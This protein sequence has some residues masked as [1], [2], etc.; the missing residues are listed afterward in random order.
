MRHAKPKLALVLAVAVTFL[1]PLRTLRAQNAPPAPS[2]AYAQAEAL[3]RAG[4]MDEGIAAAK[5]VLE[6]EPRNL[7][8]LNLLGIA[9][10]SKGDLD[11]ANREYRKAL[12]ID[13]AFYHALKN[14][15]INEL[16]QKNVAGAKRDLTAALKFA[17]NDPAIHASLGKIAYAERDYSTAVA[18]LSKIDVSKDAELATE[19]VESDLQA[20]QKTS[21]EAV[22]KQF[23]PADFSDRQQFR[24][25]LAL[26][27]R[28]L[29]QD[30]VPYFQAVSTK[31]PESYDAAF[32]LA[33]CLIETKQFPQAIEVLRSSA[34]QSHKT[35]E[36]D[37]LLAEAYEGNTQ[38]QEAINTLREA[39]QLAPEDED[40]FVDLA[41]LCTN[42]EAFQIALDVIE[43]ALHYHP[44]SDR[45]IFQRGVVY[46]MTNKFD[47]AEQDFQTAARLAP[48]KNL[49]YV[50][51][52]VSYMQTGN[53]PKAIKE[54]QERVRKKPNDATLH[55]LLGEALIRAGAAPGEANF[56]EAK[57]ALQKSVRLSP[58]FGPS[59]VDLAKLYLK[60][61]A[62]DS[63]IEHLEIAR[64]LDPKDKSAY[65]QLA[66]AYRRKGK[67]EMATTM[68]TALNKLNEEERIEAG[69]RKR[70]HMVSAP[71]TSP[72]DS[73]Q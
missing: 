23:A 63:A 28:D 35:S 46:A 12:A 20:G 3:V 34:A 7:K 26:A 72:A 54:L 58:K 27:G 38:T 13:P 29:L 11:A 40:N 9:L 70:L 15:A 53:L 48:E 59:H 42:Y 52:G 66:V 10:T 5:Q 4:Q 19:L 73:T 6:S 50:A 16:K 57:L 30:A 45:L 39:T 32:N 2:S 49:S 60:E 36:L 56:R 8:A 62:L 44:Q 31:H 17:P 14:L 64:K 47:Q 37:N 65:S 1:L 51:M 33:L 61:N 69:H 25:G 68:L 55:Y 24:L 71:D 21:A 22:L 41:A 18:H 67:P 43:V